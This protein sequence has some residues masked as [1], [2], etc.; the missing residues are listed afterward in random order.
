VNLK[1]LFQQGGS[2]INGTFKVEGGS[3]SNCDPNVLKNLPPLNIT[4][5]LDTAA[6]K[7]VVRIYG[8]TYF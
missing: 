2:P 1:K 5:S 4:G 7:A 3:V 6:H 8:K